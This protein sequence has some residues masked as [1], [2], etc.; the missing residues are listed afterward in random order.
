MLA[1]L[2]ET[3]WEGSVI[4][5]Q[6]QQ[7]M[8]LCRSKRERLCELMAF[9]VSTQSKERSAAALKRQQASKKPVNEYE[10]Y[11]AL[12]RDAGELAL[13]PIR[14]PNNSTIYRILVARKRNSNENHFS[15]TH[16]Y[17]GFALLA[18]HHTRHSPRTRGCEP[19]TK[20][21][22]ANCKSGSSCQGQ[23]EPIH[24]LGESSQMFLSLS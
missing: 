8:L 19:Y 11:E 13:T 9:T 21:T 3:R 20:A 2:S 12:V 6:Q 14:F 23:E 7:D 17:K 5:E 16:K 1:I 18:I 15:Y 4:Q 22:I 24:A 10:S